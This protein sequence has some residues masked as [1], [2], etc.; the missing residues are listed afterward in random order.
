[1]GGVNNEYKKIKI[2]IRFLFNA[3]VEDPIALER[4][5]IL[6]QFGKIT[7]T[8]FCL[9]EEE[10]KELLNLHFLEKNDVN[11]SRAEPRLI[12]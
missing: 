9:I 6:I 10:L 1:M 5:R 3:R 4:E 7:N 8:P 11:I 2:M 12:H